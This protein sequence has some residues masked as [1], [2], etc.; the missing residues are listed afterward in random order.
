M[1]IFALAC[2]PKA[3][4]ALHCDQH[5]RKM[6]IETAQMLYTFLHRLR[7]IPRFRELTK[8][9]VDADGNA[10]EPYKPTHEHHPC[11]LWLH[12]GRSHYLWLASLGMH[13]CW[14]Y[15]EIYGKTHKTAVHI[16]ALLAFGAGFLAY[17]PD[18]CW[19]AEWLRRL[20]AIG[21][22]PGSIASCAAKV[23]LAD[24][25]TNCH[26]GVACMGDETVPL[27]TDEHGHASTIYSYRSLM[28]HKQA[29]DLKNMRW[30]KQDEVPLALTDWVL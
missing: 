4:A 8:D 16:K 9:L 3:A 26:F 6:I 10:L 24:P 30:A 21:E 27:E 19:P 23:C 2:H 13:L 29:V 11:Q 14:R 22:S 28:G 5:V 17:L 15:E 20:A 18:D 7:L 25:P 1:N 12:G